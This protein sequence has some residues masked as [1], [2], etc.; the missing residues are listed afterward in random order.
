M[1]NNRVGQTGS[2]VVEDRRTDRDQ[3]VTPDTVGVGQLLMFTWF[4]AAVAQK[5]GHLCVLAVILAH[6]EDQSLVLNQVPGIAGKLAAYA[7]GDAGG[8][9]NPD[10]P[11]TAKVQTQ[12]VVKT[13]EMVDVSV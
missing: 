11:A 4:E 8:T 7:P 1:F 5:L 6:L 3:L 10:P 13:N 2:T 9:V 12:E